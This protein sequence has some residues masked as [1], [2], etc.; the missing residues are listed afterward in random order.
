MKKPIVIAIAFIAITLVSCENKTVE[1]NNDAVKELEVKLTATE[2]QLIN[3]SA[4]LARCKGETE[5]I[6]VDST[7][8]DNVPVN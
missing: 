6:E 3:V 1:T 4:E 7:Q 8:L 5:S 2:A